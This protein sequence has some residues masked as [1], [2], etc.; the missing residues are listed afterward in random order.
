MKNTFFT[1]GK[2]ILCGEHTVL[3]GGEALVFPLKCMGI[4][5]SYTRRDS[6]SGLKFVISG[7]RGQE[8]EPLLSGVIQRILHL[9]SLTGAKINGLVECEN[10]L[11]LGAGLGA[12]A[13]LSVSI[14]RW[15]TE[16]LQL[17]PQNKMF[18]NSKR[19]EDLFHGESSG[20]DVA[21]VLQQKPLV[22]SRT[23]GFRPLPL[24]WQPSMYLSYSGKRGMTSECVLQVKELLKNHPAQGDALDLNM[25][26]SVEMAQRALLMGS[27]EKAQRELILIQSL[28][29]ARQVFENWG[30]V[31]P[32]M[33]SE[34]I[35][36]SEA[37]ALAV[38]P[39][40]SGGGGY[41]LSLWEK[42]MTSKQCHELGLIP[43]F[44]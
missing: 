12:S 28:K 35:K 24:E 39:T 42:P 3:R 36:L 20:V 6:G 15:L 10:D 14:V 11:P 19:V 4:R 31:D 40:G 29:L 25:K 21:V 5:W 43:C 38:K 33:N 30:L 17:L 18:E 32:V 26:S 7:T 22:F 9:F 16:D 27:S 1:P 2:W 23:Q 8:L 34:I 37:G 13:A 41:L 44:D